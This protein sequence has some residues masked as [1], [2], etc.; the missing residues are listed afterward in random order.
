MRKKNSNKCTQHANYIYIQYVK[1]K[2]TPGHSNADRFTIASITTHPLFI[3][4][5]L[6]ISFCCDQADTIFTFPSFIQKKI[7]TTAT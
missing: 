7:S 3:Q 1:E 4:M 6:N 5:S 2:E